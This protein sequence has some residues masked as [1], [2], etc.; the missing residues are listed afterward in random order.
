LNISR[1][2]IGKN[3]NFDFKIFDLKAE[4]LAVKIN[5]RY[6]S[7][8]FKAIKSPCK[9]HT[10]LVSIFINK[11]NSSILIKNKFSTESEDFN[12]IFTISATSPQDALMILETDK[13]QKLIDCSSLNDSIIN[14]LKVIHFYK[15]NVFFLFNEK[16]PDSLKEISDGVE[17]TVQK[18]IQNM[19]DILKKALQLQTLFN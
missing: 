15:G 3:L 18:E 10:S 17:Q 9:M 1:C 8:F 11:N 12:K 14:N 13:I 2:F 16:E 4:N 6:V 19:E 5:G 7:E